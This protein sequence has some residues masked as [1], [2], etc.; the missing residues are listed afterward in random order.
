MWLVMSKLECGRSIILFNGITHFKIEICS[1]NR[2]QPKRSQLKKTVVTFRMMWVNYTRCDEYQQRGLFS[3][4]L[5]FARFGFCCRLVICYFTSSNNSFIMHS[6]YLLC[7]IHCLISCCGIYQC[8]CGGAARLLHTHTI[9]LKFQL[10]LQSSWR[11]VVVVKG[12]KVVFL[13]YFDPIIIIICPVPNHFMLLLSVCVCCAIEASKQTPFFSLPQPLDHKFT[14]LIF[15]D[16][17]N[18]F[19]ALCCMRYATCIK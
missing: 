10:I 13:L 16:D 2:S 3:L 11:F 1:Y 17:F 7:S 15:Y 8:C 4:F 12:S 6:V 5:I 19:V 14:Y 9:S 18:I